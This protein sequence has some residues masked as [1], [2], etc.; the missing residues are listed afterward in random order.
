M[1][2]LLTDDERFSSTI[3]EKLPT[4]HIEQVNCKQLKNGLIGQSEKPFLII[5]LDA[6][7]INELEKVG[8]CA[9]IALS[10]I[11]R[12]DEAMIVLHQGIRGYGNKYMLPENLM[13]T[14]ETVRDGQ[15]W[16][17]PSIL[18][19]MISMLPQTDKP[20]TTKPT[21]YQLTDKELEVAKLV[22]K[23]YSNKEIAVEMNITVRTVKSHM[24][25]IFNKTGFRDRLEL[26]INFK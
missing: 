1:I 23:G 18:T 11:P 13:Q 2:L 22:A 9:A 14:V 7:D 21:E 16:L 4:E 12:Y 3:S 10:N 15:V 24:T 6:V 25:S 19:T 26:A 8:C 20:K 5:D 17:P